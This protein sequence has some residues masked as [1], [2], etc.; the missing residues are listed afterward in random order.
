MAGAK[1][2]EPCRHHYE[3]SY[4]SICF[5]LLNYLPPIAGMMPSWCMLPATPLPRASP[6]LVRRRRA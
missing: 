4:R 1:C 6:H 5:M 3:L 2:G